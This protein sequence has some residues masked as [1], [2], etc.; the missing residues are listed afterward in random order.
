MT[1]APPGGAVEGRKKRGPH[2]SWLA[3]AVG[4]EIA[5]GPFDVCRRA[6]EGE[7]FNAHS[8]RIINSG[9]ARAPAERES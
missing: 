8:P 4:G 7:R 5:R 6:L 3:S 1:T 9:R 2:S